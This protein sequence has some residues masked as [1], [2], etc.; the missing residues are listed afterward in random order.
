MVATAVF[1]LRQLRSIAI[2][3]RKVFRKTLSMK[4]FSFSEIREWRA[5]M[6]L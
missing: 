4:N 2:Q 3:K 6:W 1:T 5:M